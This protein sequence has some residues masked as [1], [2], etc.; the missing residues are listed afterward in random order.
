MCSTTSKGM[1]IRGISFSETMAKKFKKIMQ[2]KERM[3]RQNNIVIRGISTIE[4]E[5]K[6]F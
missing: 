2:K 1:Y 6:I 4:M 5:K 3:E